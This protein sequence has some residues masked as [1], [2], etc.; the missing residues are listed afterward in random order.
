MDHTVDAH[1]VNDATFVLIA[2]HDNDFHNVKAA[3]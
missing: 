2:T 1:D 3:P